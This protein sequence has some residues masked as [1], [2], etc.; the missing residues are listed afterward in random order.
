LGSRR[1]AVQQLLDKADRAISAA[2]GL[3]RRAFEHDAV[4][5]T[6]RIALILKVRVFLRGP[7]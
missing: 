4:G 2:L 1:I 7:G 6:N 5:A 3:D